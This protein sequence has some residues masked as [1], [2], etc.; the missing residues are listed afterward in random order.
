MYLELHYFESGIVEGAFKQPERPFS[1]D[2][3]KLFLTNVL[4]L[5]FTGLVI[6]RTRQ[7]AY[8]GNTP[9]P[10]TET[11]NRTRTTLFRQGILER[12]T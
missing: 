11:E 2:M 10:L 12:R 1:A 8:K 7:V 6:L 5:I 9:T 3:Q 4:M